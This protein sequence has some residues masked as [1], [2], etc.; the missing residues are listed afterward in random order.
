MLRKFLLSLIFPI[1][2]L[3]FLPSCSV[4]DKAFKNFEINI[5]H[6][7]D[8]A[9]YVA[10]RESRAMAKRDLKERFNTCPSMTGDKYEE[11]MDEIRSFT[12]NIDKDYLAR[13]DTFTLSTRG[14][15]KIYL[16]GRDEDIENK[17]YRAFYNKKVLLRLSNSIS[18]PNQRIKV[19][20]D[21]NN[22]TIESAYDCDSLSKVGL[23]GD[24][25]I[26][27]KWQIRF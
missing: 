16:N 21:I 6:V 27:L 22:F 7:D 23:K 26:W 24:S 5:Q 12:P 11:E 14:K 9:L 17:Y 4:V 8:L 19:S 13:S 2:F 1:L 20:F 25:Q 15:L 10:A 18:I 3:S